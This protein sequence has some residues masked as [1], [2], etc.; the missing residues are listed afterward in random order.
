M[1]Q[2]A[3]H[4]A[5]VGQFIVD[6]DGSLRFLHVNGDALRFEM[7][8]RRRACSQTQRHTAAENDHLASVVD[9]FLDIGGLNTWL[10]SSTGFVPVPNT[11]TARPEFEVA[12]AAHF[13]NVHP[14]P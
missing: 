1:K 5:A 2:P 8:D 10:V 9:Q 6:S 14:S 13:F 12:A 7:L 11:S 4:L 3:H